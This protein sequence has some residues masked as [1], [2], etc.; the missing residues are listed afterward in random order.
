MTDRKED[1]NPEIFKCIQC[2]ETFDEAFHGEPGKDADRD[3]I[4]N[5]CAVDFDRCDNCGL[6]W[7]KGDQEKCPDCGGSL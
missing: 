3:P 5:D 2:D 6:L 4:C 7:D 1:F